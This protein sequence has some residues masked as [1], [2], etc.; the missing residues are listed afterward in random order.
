MTHQWITVSNSLATAIHVTSVLFNP[1]NKNKFKKYCRRKT[2]QPIRVRTQFG[3]IPNNSEFNYST[4]KQIFFENFWVR[5]TQKFRKSDN[6]RNFTAKFYL[7]T[8]AS[9]SHRAWSARGE[10]VAHAKGPA[11]APAFTV[12]RLVWFQLDCHRI[13]IRYYTKIMSLIF[14][15]NFCFIWFKKFGSTILFGWNLTA[16]QSAEISKIRNFAPFVI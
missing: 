3:E 10:A 14:I 16:N 13:T 5:K 11:Y 6:P 9:V 12:T 4:K 1:R 2:Q 8:S 7:Q 15:W